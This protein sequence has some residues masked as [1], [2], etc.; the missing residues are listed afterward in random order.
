M[1][2]LLTMAKYE[3]NVLLVVINNDGGGIFHK[4]PIREYEPEFTS[5]FTTPHGLE[6]EAAAELYGIPYRK[7]ADLHQLA[8]VFSGFIMEKGPKI[9]EIQVDRDQNWHC[10]REIL[11][12]VNKSIDELR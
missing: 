6:F 3:L 12:E 1:N 8:E 9:I 2:G 4:L 5:Y 7:A 10:H 11:L